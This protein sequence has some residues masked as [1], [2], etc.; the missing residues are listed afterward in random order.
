LPIATL[1][2][3]EKKIEGKGQKVSNFR[4]STVGRHQSLKWLFAAEYPTFEG[5]NADMIGGSIP[6]SNSSPRISACPFDMK[7]P[8]FSSLQSITGI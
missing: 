8:G 2:S 3:V 4:Q 1:P 7:S 6:R 5:Q